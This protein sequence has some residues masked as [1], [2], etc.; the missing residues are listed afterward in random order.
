MQLRYLRESAGFPR[1]GRDFR[2]DA[3][4]QVAVGLVSDRTAKWPRPA[5]L[6]S[7][8]LAKLADILTRRGEQSAAL[9]AAREGLSTVEKT[10]HR[11][12]EAELLRLEG[13]ALFG[14][15][16]LEESQ[17]ALE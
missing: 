3:E 9:A 10:G 17:N 5:R 15:N 16:M 14:L 13:V 8:G 7:Y 1:C 12:W 2:S 4:Q 6:R 11:Q